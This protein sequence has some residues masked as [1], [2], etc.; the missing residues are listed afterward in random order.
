MK[1]LVLFFTCITFAFSHISFYLNQLNSNI[2]DQAHILSKSS[3]LILN[4][5]II[6]L[7][8]SKDLYLAVITIDETFKEDFS[9][10]SEKLLDEFNKNYTFL[11]AL[12]SEKKVKILHKNTLS[13]YGADKILNS[14]ILPNFQIN[15]FESGILQ[16][17]RK[18]IEVL[19]EQNQAYIKSKYDTFDRLSFALIFILIIST[20][21][22][23]ISLFNKNHQN[24]L[25]KYSLALIFSSF[26]TL[27][28][29][30]SIL[31]IF[32][33]TEYIAFTS[34]ILFLF[35]FV[36]FSQNKLNLKH[37]IKSVIYTTLLIVILV[38]ILSFFVDKSFLHIFSTI[39]F[40]SIFV[41]FERSI[42]LGV[43]FFDNF[44]ENI[45]QDDFSDDGNY[46]DGGSDNS[47]D[48]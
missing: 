17:S 1:K 19:L 6:H 13:E 23:L 18:I 22:F 32:N 4:E 34:L 33:S 42:I 47:G 28:F 44:L 15:K 20:I 38:S 12:P 21:A 10:F 40:S 3:K 39:G 35:Y 36:I 27:A 31:Y 5:Q 25:S 45:L 37:F 48:T 14:Y 26:F 7:Q 9:A 30:F 2:I 11:I 43:E 16:G 24:A 41:L 46:F 8:N 29:M